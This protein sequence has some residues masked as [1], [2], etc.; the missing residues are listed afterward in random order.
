MPTPGNKLSTLFRSL[1]PDEAPLQA[2]KTAAL[3]DA[4]QRWPL[5]KAVAPRSAAQTPPLSETDRQRWSNPARPNS[6]AAAKAPIT[7][8]SFSGK[9]AH[10]L[11]KISE[12]STASA[13]RS[14]PSRTAA[15]LFP[16]EPVAPVAAR[17]V[18][19]ASKAPAA[20]RAAPAPAEPVATKGFLA[21]LANKPEPAP[22]AKTTR[23][24]QAAKP[25]S[26]L[27][28]FAEPA[29][30]AAPDSLSAVFGRIEGKQQASTPNNT[31]AKPS[32]LSRLGK[33]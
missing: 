19:A 33:R 24:K 14:A 32:F 16:G 22:P 13:G 29:P 30:S 6:S 26:F 23:S 11:A 2:S 12:Q 25:E 27:A 7:L 21:A 3:Q 18:P 15:K 28:K 1:G 20:R 9:L 17:A 10:G 5:F 8:P 31:K 4:E